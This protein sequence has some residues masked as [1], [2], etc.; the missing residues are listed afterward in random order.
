[1]KGHARMRVMVAAWLAAALVAACGDGGEPSVTEKAE[2]AYVGTLG[3][4]V[5]QAVVLENDEVWIFYGSNQGETFR[6][7]GFV[8]GPALSVSGSLRTSNTLDYG[9]KPALNVV[10]ASTYLPG[11]RL[12]GSIAPLVG[13]DATALNA[14]AFAAATYD[15]NAAPSLGDIQGNWT[16]SDTDGTSVSMS[17]QAD[18]V[19]N[20]TGGGCAFSGTFVP[21]PTGKNVFDATLSFQGAPCAA[22][23]QSVQGV[24]MLQSL[25]SG[26]KQ[27][28]VGAIT[29]CRGDAGGTERV[30]SAVLFGVR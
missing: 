1:M 8:Q 17:I 18:G 30:K 29:S 14:G 19:F 21:H 5:A 7:S 28:I 15:F 6:P 22:A 16:L 10:L 23:D 25:A 11:T 2:G 13:G 12:T 20:A 26:R 9:V 24:A 27:L 3:P 4:N